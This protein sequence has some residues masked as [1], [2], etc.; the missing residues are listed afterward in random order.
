MLSIKNI[1]NYI[2]K[3]RVDESV[4]KLVVEFSVD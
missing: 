1:D 3:L 2:Y 4:E